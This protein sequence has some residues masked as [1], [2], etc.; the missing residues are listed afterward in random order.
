MPTP[1]DDTAE[2]T[3]RL[4]RHEA[5]LLA[6]P[7]VSGCGIGLAAGS[8]RPVIQVFVAAASA[9][10]AVS[11]AAAELLGTSAFDVVVMPPPSG[12]ARRRPAR[13]RIEEDDS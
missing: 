7:G 4:K 11:R 13:D 3:A 2:L 8:D 12:D 9:T 6:I 1:P 5:A 10:A